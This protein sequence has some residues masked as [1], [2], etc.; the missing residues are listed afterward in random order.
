MTGRGGSRSLSPP[1]QA[2][3][4]PR[5]GGPTFEL[6]S[7]FGPFAFPPVRW[8]RPELS[9][10]VLSRC[11]SSPLSARSAGLAVR[12][13]AGGR[14][15]SVGGS[16]GRGPGAMTP[17]PPIP[18]FPC[19]G[20]PSELGR[21]GGRVGCSARFSSPAGSDQSACFLCFLGRLI[22]PPGGGA[23]WTAGGLWERV[24]RGCD[25]FCVFPRPGAVTSVHT[26]LLHQT[27]AADRADR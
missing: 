11:R 2:R 3:A 4:R 7:G 26:Q 27:P 1:G 16:A 9:S 21:G 23:A 22:S 6:S 5:D 20:A 8:L 17:P 19:R 14:R 25:G 10:P 24:T 18:L 15:V 12:A 13:G